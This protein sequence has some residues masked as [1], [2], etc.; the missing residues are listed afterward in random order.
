MS[1][2]APGTDG[3]AVHLER[4]R[5]VLEVVL[6]A[7][8]VG[9]QLAKLAHGH[10]ANTELVRDRRA[11]DEAARLHADDDVDVALP[12]P[13]HEPVDGR[14]ERLAVLEERR[15]VLEQDARLGEVG[16]VA[17]ARREVLRRHRH[18]RRLIDVR[19]GEQSLHPMRDAV[20]HDDAHVGVRRGAAIE[21]RQQAEEMA[22]EDPRHAAVADHENALARV[23]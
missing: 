2:F 11:E 21:S 3:V 14:L 13:L 4:G 12:H 22:H 15:D 18:A 6:D 10:E 7:D 1:T 16:D 19:I 9:R 5:A 17:D 8:H 23:L 20:T